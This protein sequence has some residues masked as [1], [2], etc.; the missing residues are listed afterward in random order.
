MAALKDRYANAL[1]EISDE[2]GSLER[3]LEQAIIL[4]DTL[5]GDEV[6]G[7]IE[8]PHVPNAAKQ[9]FFNDAFSE[10]I[11]EHLMN[12]LYLAVRK[13]RESYLVPVLTEFIALAKRRLGRI[14]AKLVS[15][16]PLTKAQIESVR[17]VLVEKTKMQV[18]L[19]A[20]VDPDVIGG[21]YVL[22]DGQIFDRTVRSEL[23]L[24][25][26]HLKRGG[27]AW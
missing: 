21:F 26:E 22:V 23:N 18:E 10:W 13:N 20:S 4:L 5:K 2:N 25:R 8:H 11:S 24:M 1:L 6:K 3:D 27:C 12:F 16:K 17:R 7:F 19:E 9:Q 15:A 14:E